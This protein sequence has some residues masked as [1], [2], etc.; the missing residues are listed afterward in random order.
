[1]CTQRVLTH[2]DAAAIAA[3][4]PTP[5][6]PGSG[7]LPMPRTTLEA[8]YFVALARKEN[9]F[10]FWAAK[11]DTT[12]GNVTMHWITEG[13]S[14]LVVHQ[15]DT[16]CVLVSSVT[17]SGASKMYASLEPCSVQASD[18]V[19]FVAASAAPPPP[20]GGGEL[21]RFDPMRVPPPPPS[22]KSAALSIYKRETLF[23]LTEAVCSG[24][25]GEGHIHRDICTKFLDEIGKFQFIYGVGTISP[26]CGHVCWHSCNGDHLGGED[27]DDFTNCH[28]TEC[29]ESL[30]YDFLIRC[31][32][33]TV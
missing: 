20:P 29:A 16:R 11:P 17:S 12:N 19:L 1:M 14:E 21:H 18:G 8:G 31:A 30:C 28:K 23:P 3:Q 6:A 2:A 4:R 7:G 27:H 13:G 9:V 15:G 5:A 10:S 26:L 33:N 32:F 22:I 25:A 24:K